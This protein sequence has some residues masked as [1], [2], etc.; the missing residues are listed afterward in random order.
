[1]EQKY[2]KILIF[3]GVLILCFAIGF[4]IF[5]NSEFDDLIIEQFNNE[6]NETIEQYNNETSDEPEFLSI[7]AD[8]GKVKVGDIL[9]ITAEI[10]DKNGIEKVSAIMP[11]DNGAD[12]IQLSLISGDDKSG[13]WQGQWKCHGTVNKEYITTVTAINILGKSAT[14]EVAWWDDTE[15]SWLSGWNHRIKLTIDS[16]KVDANLSD[17][18]VLV[19]L[20]TLSGIGDVDVSCVFD[21]LTS[22]DNRKKIAVTKSDGTT[23]C[24]VEI[25]K[26]DDANEQAWLWTKVSGA[27]SVLAASDTIL[28]LYYDVDHADNTTYVGDSGSAGGDGPRESVWDANYKMIQH[29]EES[30][31][32]D[33]QGHYDSTSND[34]DGTPKNFQDAGGGTTDAIGQVDGADDFAGD[35]DYVDCGND[36]SLDVTDAIT[37]EAWA[38]PNELSQIQT[39]LSKGSYSL[40]INADDKPFFTIIS[41][42]VSDWA[43]TGDLVSATYVYSLAV[44]NGKLYAGAETNGNVF[45]YDEGTD[46]WANTG[47]LA[48]ATCVFSLAVLNGKLYAGTIPNGD[49]FVYDE[50]TDTWANTGNLASATYVYSLAVFNGKLYAGTYPNGNVFVY[51]EGTDTWANTG[52]LTSATYAFSLSVFNGKLYAGTYPNG[53]VFVYDEGT[54]TWTNTGDLAS[55]TY[56]YSLS[57]FNGKLYAGTY[58]NGDVFVYDEGT[59][60]WANTGNLASAT[61]VFSL[62]VFNGKLYAGTYINGDVFVY[63]EG[64]DTWANTG[65]LASATRVYSLSVFNGKLYAGTGFNGDVFVAGNGSA[66]YSDIALTS[67]YVHL[68]ATYDKNKLKIYLNGVKNTEKDFGSSI[69]VNILD[70]LIGNSYG[71]SQSP[72]GTG[73]EENFNGSIDDVRITNDARTAAEIKADYNSGNDSLVTFGSAIE[74]RPNTPAVSPHGGGFMMF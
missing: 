67:N 34:N 17:F 33:A 25:E 65:N 52:D 68:A 40:K 56:V 70:L 69:I 27:D 16:S 50:G 6:T 9:A 74:K 47:N 7:T 62:A 31:N 21:E 43:N 37:I 48:S 45:V 39:I 26:W 64:T 2:F 71:T 36:S 1:M 58:P 29:L 30:P 5:Y 61:C 55:A 20:S 11:H 12:E 23:Q 42:D 66:V 63:D 35:D 18:P 22:D 4:F 28:Y 72:Y 49:V 57:V 3:S 32:D 15:I 53:N 59:D 60:T 14:D 10:K 38:K 13:V 54:D 24:Y 41:E 51:D 73:L 44:F 8:P 46:T 19:Y